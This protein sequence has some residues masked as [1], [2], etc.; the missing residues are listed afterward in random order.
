MKLGMT[1]MWFTGEHLAFSLPFY[2]FLD[3]EY[4]VNA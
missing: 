4:N 2:A 1:A 3:K